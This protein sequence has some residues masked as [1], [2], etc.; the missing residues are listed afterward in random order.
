MKTIKE[1][2]WLFEALLETIAMW[3]L[4]ILNNVCGILN[5][6]N[7]A[8]LLAEIHEKLYANIFWIGVYKVH[9]SKTQVGKGLRQ[10]HFDEKVIEEIMEI[11]DKYI[12]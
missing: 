5:F 9:I 3:I 1:W 4:M 10:L 8:N 2:I 11:F 12:E 7:A 6:P